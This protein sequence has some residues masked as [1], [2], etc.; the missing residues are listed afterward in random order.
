M[1]ND[2]IHQHFYNTQKFMYAPILWDSSKNIKKSIPCKVIIKKKNE[3]DKVRDFTCT[4][5]G[6]TT[7][8]C[9]CQSIQGN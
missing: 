9:N 2:I 5:C 3:I 6:Q 8:W 7:Y 1:M 4:R